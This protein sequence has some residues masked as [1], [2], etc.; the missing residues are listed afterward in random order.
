MRAITILTHKDIEW[1][2]G[3]PQDKAFN[4]LKK[5]LTDAPALGYYDPVMLVLTE[6]VLH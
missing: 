2:W 3:E 4:K 5:L 6:L 1:Y